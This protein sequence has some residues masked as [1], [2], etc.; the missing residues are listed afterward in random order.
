METSSGRSGKTPAEEVV[1][2]AGT[3]NAIKA[4]NADGELRVEEQGIRGR[5]RPNGGADHAAAE[6]MELFGGVMRP[7]RWRAGATDVDHDGQLGL[8]EAP[9]WRHTRHPRSCYRPPMAG[10]TGIVTRD[11][12]SDLTNP[13]HRRSQTAATSGR[14][15][16]NLGRCAR[17]RWRFGR[18][19]R[20]AGRRFFRR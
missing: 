1:G 10:S 4:V 19:T 17:C 11:G 12:G 13:R 8:V 2:V 7:V 16:R 9:A 20:H 6:A 14:S 18:G 15:G 5:E 3:A